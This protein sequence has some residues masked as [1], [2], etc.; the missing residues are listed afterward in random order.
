MILEST[1]RAVARDPDDPSA[2][3]TARSAASRAGVPFGCARLKPDKL[4][5][6]GVGDGGSCGYGGCGFGYGN[7]YGDGYGDLYK[8]RSG[9][10][11]GYGNARGDG[12][13]NGDFYGG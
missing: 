3:R 1:A 13:G 12:N 8:Y 4:Y 6:D 5:G 2:Y 10:G 11:D 7:I 9:S